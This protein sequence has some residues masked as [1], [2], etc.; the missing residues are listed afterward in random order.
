MNRPPIFYVRWRG[1][2]VVLIANADD[3]GDRVVLGTP[4]R[5]IGYM[6]GLWYFTGFACA[7][8]VTTRA[9]WERWEQY[10][11]GRADTSFVKS[12]KNGLYVPERGVLPNPEPPKVCPHG[13][14]GAYCYECD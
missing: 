8:T 6:Y 12:V 13:S 1:G 7:K 3:L 9:E 10:V 11:N 5:K 2:F 4:G 14:T